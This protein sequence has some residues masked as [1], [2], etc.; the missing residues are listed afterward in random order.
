MRYLLVDRITEIKPKEKVRGIKLFSKSEDLFDKAFLKRLVISPSLII[1][2]AGQIGSWLIKFSMD[3][4]VEPLATYI[5]GVR[6][7][8]EVLLGHLLHLEAK[9]ISIDK[10]SSNVYLK[11]SGNGE[12][13]MEVDRVMFVH[14][15]IH[16]KKYHSISRE[17]FELL[18]Q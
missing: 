7:Y 4:K 11:V 16:D 18:L 13:V 6:I 14:L 17:R 2:A 1:E 8:K 3:F 15:P 12:M 5:V 9:I 10:R